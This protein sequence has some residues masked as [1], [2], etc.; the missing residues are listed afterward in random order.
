MPLGARTE[1]TKL[2]AALE[3]AHWSPMAS[4]LEPP[5][6]VGPIAGS[7]EGKTLGLPEGFVV[8]VKE[9]IMLGMTEGIL[10]GLELGAELGRPDS[11][12]DPE[13]APLAGFLVGL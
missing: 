4:S 1:G 12:G 5:S 11:V 9:G 13:G 2:G 6:S 8:G 3:I 10:L 7:S